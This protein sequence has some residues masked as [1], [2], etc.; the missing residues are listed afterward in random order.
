M[1]NQDKPEFEQLDPLTNA[2]IQMLKSQLGQ[3][4]IAG[5]RDLGE[6][7]G[8]L[9]QTANDLMVIAYGKRTAANRLLEIALVNA[10]VIEIEM[11]APDAPA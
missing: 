5:S 4:S 9:F 7:V 11:G 2:R 1:P 6:A 3:E 10:E 8:A